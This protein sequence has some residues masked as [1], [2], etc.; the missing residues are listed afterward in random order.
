MLNRKNVGPMLIG[1]SIALGL[2]ALAAAI[3]W[4]QQGMNVLI[5][6]LVFILYGIG[7]WMTVLY[8][9]RIQADWEETGEVLGRLQQAVSDIPAALDANLKSI[10]TRL[11]EG[12][13]QALAKLQGEVNEG[14]RATL[15]KG[16]LQ[17]GDSLEKNLKQPLA[18]LEA[19][20]AAWAKQA[21]AQSESSRAL[22]EEMRKS[23]REGSEEAKRL[24]QGLAQDLKSLTGAQS[25]QADRLLS[26]WAERAAASQTESEARLAAL[27]D[28][29]IA[30]V[31]SKLREAQNAQAEAQ[32]GLLAQALA[33]V[34][35]QA[36]SSQ[37]AISAQVEALQAAAAEQSQSLRAATAEQSK[38][39]QT[40][41]A[42]QTKA[43]QV[44]TT[45]QTKAMQAAASEQTQ[46]MR[47]GAADLIKTWQEGL[48]EQAE[49]GQTAA[50]TQAQALR[51]ASETFAQGLVELKDTSLRLVSE[52]EAKASASLEAQSQLSL[53]VA[54]KVSELADRMRQ[55][56]QDVAELA[57][58]AQ[59]NQTE[60][61]AGVAMLN[62][63]LSSILDR[64]EKQASAGDG[65][66]SLLAELGKTLADFQDRSAEVLV[67]NALKTQ[68]ILM[69][70]LRSQEGRA[71]SA[72]ENA[73]ATAQ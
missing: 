67:E 28:A 50:E 37:E 20:L 54:G 4:W 57:H 8:W 14:A 72:S 47:A 23:Q 19:H 69:E 58:V 70:V 43:L 45:E 46:A 35:A 15:E 2:F 53:E 34:E 29:V 1:T 17:I 18:S 11:T 65:Y 49:A 22:G 41:A 55:G 30:D 62:A 36:K 60:M 33:G 44:A 73:L 7:Q 16:A 56:S 66:Q 71:G 31:T 51:S 32:Q 63:G 26:A 12:Q 9:Q 21:D 38:A 13:V 64:L 42:E 39:L 40:A 24:A 6:S 3:V 5:G 25:A 61:Q 68:E 59:I 48:T 52:V 10:A 27:R